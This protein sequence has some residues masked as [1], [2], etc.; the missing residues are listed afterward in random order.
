[1]SKCII[2]QLTEIFCII[3]NLWVHKNTKKGKNGEGKGRGREKDSQRKWGEG[4]KTGIK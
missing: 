4:E 2:R 3:K 1:M